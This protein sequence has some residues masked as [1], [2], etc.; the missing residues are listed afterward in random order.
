MVSRPVTEHLVSQRSANFW[1]VL[2]GLGFLPMRKRGRREEKK[3]EEK[4]VFI[5]TWKSL[6]LFLLF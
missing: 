4:R 2:M 3:R 5:I 6:F 1:K